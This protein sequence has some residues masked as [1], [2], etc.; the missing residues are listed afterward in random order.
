MTRIEICLDDIEGAVVAE[1]CGAA[2]IEL[3]AA[4]GVGGLT[5]SIGTVETVLAT[6]S[7][8]GVQVL[9]RPREG[10]FVYTRREIEAM[11]A[12]IQAV[13]AIPAPAA[14]SVGFVLGVLTPN[15]EIDV[16]AMRAL[17]DACG[18]APVTFHKA[19]DQ[20]TDLSASLDALVALG[21]GRVLTSGG[22]ASAIDGADVLAGLVQRAGD[23][24]VVMAG[25]GVR[26]ANVAEVI[27]RTGVAEVHLRA[28]ESIASASIHRSEEFGY[29][30]GSRLVTSARMID[31]LRC[32]LPREAPG[33]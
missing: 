4:L 18:H 12:D 20:T 15:N 13:S 23:D 6:V 9:V 3:C 1:A 22:I 7:T 27:E 11:C 8:L 25:G 26:A 21:V 14:V 10:D 29:D 32:A 2:R 30:L 19:F 5:P 28:A 17:L 16:E 31:E 24:L 33:T